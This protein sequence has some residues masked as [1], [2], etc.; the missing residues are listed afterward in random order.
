MPKICTKVDLCEGHDDCPPRAF[1]TFSETVTAEGFE[2]V[3][4]GDQLHEHS[5]A[6]HDAHGA[7]VE[8]G[9]ARV[10]ANGLPVACVGSKVSCDSERLATGRPSVVVG[11]G[12]KGSR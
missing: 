1:V 8:R 3:C 6:E 10:C 7:V 11:G 2:V 4:V 9:S 5:C 12:G